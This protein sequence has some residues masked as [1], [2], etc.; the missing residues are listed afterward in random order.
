MNL[1]MERTHKMPQFQTNVDNK[2]LI[3]L[4]VNHTCP[5]CEKR[6]TVEDW[7]VGERWSCECGISYYCDPAGRVWEWEL[8]S[9]ETEENGEP[10]TSD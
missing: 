6:R 4:S 7:S 8:A 3:K 2:N 5:N 1:P 10:D 9:E